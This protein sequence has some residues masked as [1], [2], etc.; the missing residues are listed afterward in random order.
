MKPGDLV[1]TPHGVGPVVCWE[2]FP[3]LCYHTAGTRQ[4][5]CADILIEEPGELPDGSFVRVGVK[6]VHPTLSLAY[7]LPSELCEATSATTPPEPHSDPIMAMPRTYRKHRPLNGIA[8]NQLRHNIQFHRWSHP[9]DKSMMAMYSA[10]RSDLRKILRLY[11][12]NWWKEAYEHACSM[13]T[14]ARELIPQGIW[15][16][17]QSAT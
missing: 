2:V 6:G 7:Y 16:D 10:D 17:I 5:L 15:D 3:P 4:A 14:A 12:D 8:I 1:K 11:R 9:Q 13:D